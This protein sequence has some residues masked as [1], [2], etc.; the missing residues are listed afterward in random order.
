MK[1][2]PWFIPLIRPE[3]PRL[4]RGHHTHHPLPRVR[5]ELGQCLHRIDDKIGQ[6]R[7]CFFPA[8]VDRRAFAVNGNEVFG[9]EV[10]FGGGAGAGFLRGFEAGVFEESFDVMHG[11]EGGGRR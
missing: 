10:A 6:P 5:A 8:T 4:A 7:Y 1:Q 9:F 11:D 2:L 3:L